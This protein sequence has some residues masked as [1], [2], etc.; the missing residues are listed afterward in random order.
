[1]DYAEEGQIVYL[2]IDEL[3]ENGEMED[4]KEVLF[5]QELKKIFLI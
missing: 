1:M 5:I 3:E 4:V 2:T